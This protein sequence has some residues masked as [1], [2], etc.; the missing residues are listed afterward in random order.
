MIAYVSGKLVEK[1][2]TEVVLDVQGLGYRILIPTSTYE[3]LPAI[4]EKATLY[5]HHHVR[6]DAILL[7]GFAGKPERTLFETLIGVS[8]IGPKLALAVLSAMGPA[9]LRDHIAGGDVRVLTNIPGVGR[10]TAERM[11]VELRDRM[12]ALE[13]IGADGGSPLS[14]GSDT[15]GAARADALAALESLGYSRAAAEKNL[16]KVL[17]DNPGLQSADE[18]IR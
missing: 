3:S 8:G 9:E 5:T 17:R 7:Y 15:R 18:M 2:P 11:I 10:K 6:E 16:R 1:K 12:Q 13:L 4:G 14:G